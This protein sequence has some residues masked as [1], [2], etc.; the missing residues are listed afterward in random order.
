MD[1]PIETSSQLRQ[2][3]R[4]GHPEPL[5][6]RQQLRAR[7]PPGRCSP[8]TEPIREGLNGGVP[9]LPRPR[10]QDAESPDADA[11]RTDRNL[12]GASRAAARPRPARRRGAA[13]A[14]PRRQ[15]RA[16]PRARAK[17]KAATKQR[18]IYWG[19]W[20]GT[21]ADR[22]PAAL[23]HVGGQPLRRAWSARASRCSHFAAPFADCSSHP[24]RLLRL[25]HL[26]DADDPQL[27]RDPVLQLGLAV[28]PGPAATS[29]SPPSSSPTSSPA[30]T[31]TTSA[32]SPKAPATGATPSSS[33]STGR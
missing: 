32:N 8:P 11:K 7:S 30:P 6:P 33:A 27:R 28:D 26:R 14:R 15:P 13:G 2:R 22:R 9:R 16:R 25:P 12:R 18:G 5:L 19:A 24:L 23:G 1:W 3:L 4:G 10:G 20:I 29:A 31:T 21:A 17:A